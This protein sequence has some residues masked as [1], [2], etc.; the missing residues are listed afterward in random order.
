MKSVHSALLAGAIAALSPSLALASC[1][2]AFCAVNSNWTFETA[3]VEAADAFDVRFEYLHQDQPMS[4]SDKV[5]VGQVHAHHDEIQTRNRNL[6]AAYSHNFASGFGVTV[7]ANVAAREH[8][9]IHNHHG[10]K[11]FDQ[12]EYTRLGDMRVVGRYQLIDATDPLSPAAGGVT[13]GLK[14]PTGATDIANDKGDLAERSLQ[15]GTGTTD[16]I[17]GGYYHRKLAALDA[18]LFAQGQVQHAFKEHAGFRPG[19]QAN[20]DLG[21]RK[22]VADGVGLLAQLN[23]VHKRS[24]RGIEA[25]PHSSGG[26]FLYAS[27]GVSVALPANTQLYA[28]YQLPLYRKVTG[29]QLSAERAIVVGLSGQL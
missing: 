28:F 17:L 19:S 2:A 25:E 20:L 10:A 6:V 9:H 26:R 18:S 22:G 23:Y 13:F 16:L 15:P 21:V 29:V 8:S 11:L 1:G 14:L 4:G 7:S 27:P 24:D 5:G 3:A 12:W